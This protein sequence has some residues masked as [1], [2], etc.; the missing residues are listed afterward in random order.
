AIKTI[1]KAANF[2]RDKAIE[3]EAAGFVKL[4][5]TSVAQSLVGLFLSDQ[6]LKKK[7]KAYDKQARDVKL[8]AVLGAGIMGG[9][10]AYQSAVKG[11]PILM[12]DIREEG[13]Q[14][15]LD[16][17]SKLLG[18]RAIKTIQ[19]AANFGRD[20]AIEVEAAGFVKL[21]KTSVA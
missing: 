18:K 9:G 11:T 16:E 6:E 12:K 2:G 10:I 5:K 20:K 3:V 13:I 17:A 8:A 14:M 7:A 4:A 19:K 15:G 21:A 1:Q